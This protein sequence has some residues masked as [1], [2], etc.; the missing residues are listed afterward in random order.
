MNE[1]ETDALQV[2]TAQIREFERRYFAV[3]PAKAAIFAFACADAS[4]ASRGLVHADATIRDALHAIARLRPG[5]VSHV[6][7]VLDSIG[8]LYEHYLAWEAAVATQI[9]DPARVAAA[10]AKVAIIAPDF[11]DALRV[12]DE[13]QEVTRRWFVSLPP[14]TLLLVCL[15][16]LIFIAAPIAE[17]KLSSEVQALMTNETGYIAL[18]I[19]IAGTVIEHNRRK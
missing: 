11:H 19:T 9:V 7:T 4:T 15:I 8:V 6:P 18:A 13:H 14:T 12:L 3:A 10:V 5:K 2:L 1:A 17:V 16:Y